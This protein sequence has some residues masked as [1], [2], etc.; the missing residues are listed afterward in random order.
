MND[1]Y[2]P[3]LLLRSHLVIAR[4][5]EPTTEN[6]S[7]YVDSRALY[8]SICAAS[9]VAFDCDKRVRP[10]YR[11]HMHGLPD[12]SA[13][14]VELSQRL[15]DLGRA[16]LPVLREE[17]SV[18]FPSHLAAHGVFVDYRAAE[19]VI[20]NTAVRDRHHGNGQIFK[21][22]FVSFIYRLFLRNMI[23]EIFEVSSC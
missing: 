23:S 8:I 1:L 19:P 10:V 14:C 20:R 17:K 9:T 16:G 4:Q 22:L 5:T 21:A 11:L 6:I 7:P 15:K 13:F 2:N 3:F 18:L 12:R